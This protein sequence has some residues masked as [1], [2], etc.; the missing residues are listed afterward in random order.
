MSGFKMTNVRSNFEFLVY[1]VAWRDT[2][3][4]VQN[5]DVKRSGPA[6][7]LDHRLEVRFGYDVR[8]IGATGRD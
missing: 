3:R 8:V 7:S 2:D 5:A 6:H 4:S 1:G